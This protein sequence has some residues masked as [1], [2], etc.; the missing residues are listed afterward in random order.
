MG[1]REKERGTNRT[2]S[3]VV[4]TAQCTHPFSLSLSLSIHKP[5]RSLVVTA[6]RIA[7][8]I[9]V[10]LSLSCSLSLLCCYCNFVFDRKR[11][12]SFSLLIFAQGQLEVFKFIYIRMCT[13]LMCV[14]F[15]HVCVHL[16][17]FVHGTIK[18]FVGLAFASLS[19][20]FFSFIFF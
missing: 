14:I 6:S 19:F 20:W 11:R 18:L 3:S 7:L 4:W 15:M 16:Y 1:E 13:L 9:F 10:S 5:T 2:C 17:L 12:L 8:I